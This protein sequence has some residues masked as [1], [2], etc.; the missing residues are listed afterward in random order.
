MSDFPVWFQS[1]YFDRALPKEPYYRVLQIGV[2][3]GDATEWL[4]DNR[5]ILSIDDV[6]TWEGSMEHKE[7]T[8]DFSEVEKYYD[9]RF[10]EEAIVNKHK[11]TSNKFFATLEGHDIKYNFILIDGDHTASQ[12][13]IDGLNAWKYLEVGGR[14]AFDDYGWDL[15]KGDFYNPKIG[16]ESALNIFGEYGRV[17]DLGYQAWIEKVYED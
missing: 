8:I 5:N 11:M 10:H 13:A 1:G 17:I 9:S 7:M 15:G 6:D 16:I 2:Y 12:V 14:M 4:L 3:T